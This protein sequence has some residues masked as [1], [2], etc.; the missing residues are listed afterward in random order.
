MK[1]LY[2]LH[3]IITTV[4]TPFKAETKEV[5]WESF[6]REIQVCMDAGVAGFLVPCM[7]SEMNQLTHEEII[8]EV[9]ETV[10]LAH[11]RKEKCVVIPSITAKDTEE[12]MRQCREYLELG[13]DGLNLNMVYTTD[14]EYAAMV[15][16]IDDMNPD[17]LIIQD[18]SND[19]DG[20]PDRLLV[21]LFNDYK[22]VVGAKIEVK[23]SGPKYTRILKATEG[24]MNISG[25]WGSS[26]SIEAYDRGIH[27][28]MPSG[29]PELFVNVYN[30]YHAGKRDKAMELFFDMLPI[31]SFTRQAQ[32]LNR[33][34]HKLYFKRI[35][36]F[37]DAVS[38]EE[39][40]F[41]EYH[42][43]YAADLIEYAIQL[44]DNIP[45]YWA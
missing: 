40:L 30:L 14:D 23:D 33:Y 38:R 17:F 21:R 45:S 16:L 24:R 25:A 15:K 18:Q 37:T 28:L 9:R 19:D 26:Q 34:F 41:D 2:P 42:Q 1:E 8:Q 31:I 12:R 44:R 36:A 22:S 43:R 32:P 35:G 29:M 20:L 4:I 27:A 6:R 5:D 13:V 11:T 10:Q 7:A 39:V 3:G